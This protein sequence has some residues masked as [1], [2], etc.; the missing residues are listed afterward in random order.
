MEREILELRRQLASA[1]GQ[2]S[3]DDMTLQSSVSADGPLPRY[4]LPSVSTS[5]PAGLGL[6][7]TSPD[8]VDSQGA[9]LYHKESY[10]GSHEAVA[11]LLDL[12][13]GYDASSGYLLSPNG[14]NS[15]RKL[16][17]VTLSID[18]ISKLFSQ[19]VQPYTVS[20]AHNYH[21]I[22]ITGV[23]LTHCR[24]S[25]VLHIL[26]PILTIARSSET[27]RPLL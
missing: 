24:A 18:T 15:R 22:F 4:S 19:C 27:S 1:Q 14:A 16:E 10:M 25:K 2:S 6:A 5:Y 8:L 7:H 13:Q 20:S 9:E 11:S 23:W 12:R 21:F 26:P 3:V 17:D